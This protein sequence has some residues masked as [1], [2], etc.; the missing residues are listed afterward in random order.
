MPLSQVIELSNQSEQSANRK[1]NS[2]KV[3]AVSK[4][5]PD[6]KIDAD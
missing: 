6:E 2:V 3:I 1:V 4:V 5:Q